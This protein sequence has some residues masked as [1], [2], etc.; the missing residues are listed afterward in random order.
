MEEN[1]PAFPMPTVRLYAPEVW[2]P[3]AWFRKSYGPPF[4]PT[5]PM[6]RG[7]QIIADH[8]ARLR[9]LHGLWSSLRPRL[10][11]DLENLRK[12]GFSDQEFTNQF[13]ALTEVL[14]SEL[15]SAVDGL[16]KMVYGAYRDVEKVQDSSNGKLFE[17]AAQDVYGEGM[18]VAVVEALA[19]ANSA[20]FQTLRQVRTQVTHGEVGSCRQVD[21][22]VSY[23]LPRAGV[24]GGPFE[25]DD[26]ELMLKRMESGVVGL[27]DELCAVWSSALEPRDGAVACMFVSGRMYPRLVSLGGDVPSFDSGYCAFSS[28]F[29][30]TLEPCPLRDRCGAFARAE[31]S[32]DEV[33]ARMAT[34][35]EIR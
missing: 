10:D 31:A 23:R 6:P 13:T 35:D 19:R 14:F 26:V 2:G 12:H 3:F 27:V 25:V 7:M 16:R 5:G 20:W 30:E 15:Y 17:R 28:S 24:G 4:P 34:L 32:R 21:G 29:G 33:E 9:Q 1:R 18:P 8:L 22:V 11:E